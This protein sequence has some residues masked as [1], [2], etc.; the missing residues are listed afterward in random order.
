MKFVIDTSVLIDHLRLG[1][2]SSVI[3]DQIL[4]QD[5]E[6]FIPTIVVFELFSGKSAADPSVAGEIKNLLKDFKRIEFTEKIAIR[7]GELNR[8]IGRHISPQDYIVAAST[9]EI[10][11]QVVT[12]NRKDFEQIPTVSLYR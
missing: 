5:A 3:F 8:E 6:L 12:L 7:A 9:I 4:Q 2:K 10:G 11:G 1:V